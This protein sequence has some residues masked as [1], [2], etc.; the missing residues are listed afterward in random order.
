MRRRLRHV[1]ASVPLPLALLVAVGIVL[2]LSWATLQPPWNGP[3]EVGHFAYVQRTVEQREIPWYTNGEPAGVPH[4]ASAEVGSATVQS[5]ARAREGNPSMKDVNRH[6]DEVFWE[7]VET[8][9]GKDAKKKTDFMATMLNPPGF[10]LYQAAPYAATSRLDVFSRLYVLRLWN[11]PL[12]VAVIVAAW[13]F[14]GLIV[15][16]RRTLQT[17]AT[18]VVATNAQFITTT[19]SVNADAL[20]TALWSVAIALMAA[21]LLRGPT[22]ARTIALVTVTVAAGLTHG[23]GLPLVLPVA[24]TGAIAW[25]RATRPHGI[26]TRVAAG[27]AAAGAVAASTLVVLRTATGRALDFDRAREFGSYLW[28]FYLPKLEFMK[29]DLR[30][31]W[32]VRDVFIDRFWG[33]APNLDGA[34]DPWILDAMATASRIGLLALLV[35]LV[36]RWRTVARARALLLVLVVAFVTY[37]V[38]LHV[39]GYRSIIGGAGDP[40]VTGRYLIPFLVLLGAAVAVGVS[41]LPRRVLPV[42][43]SVLVFASFALHLAMLGAVMVRFHG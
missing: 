26:R 43:A 8:A 34:V 3:D 29:T 16:P 15:G 24:L 19:S 5:N 11:I 14:T 30:T 32:S 36:A 21:I 9:I 13:L 22:R 28:Q 25:W 42:V 20:V 37:L 39:A 6:P 40:V 41:W 27:V 23:R 18:A 31:D 10:P 33:I 1:R 38:V 12:I 17:L 35:V 7:E 2:S 4:G